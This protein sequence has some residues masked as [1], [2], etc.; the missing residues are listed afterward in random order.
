MNHRSPFLASLFSADQVQIAYQ[1]VEN[2]YG[3]DKIT[4]ICG[5]IWTT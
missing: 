2:M 1:T 3:V 5:T 4:P